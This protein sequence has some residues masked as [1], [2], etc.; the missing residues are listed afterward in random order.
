MRDM[1]IHLSPSEQL[2]YS[3]VRIE[4]D[5]P[6]GMSV[7]TGFYFRFNEKDGKHVP[8]I[9]TNRHV[10]QGATDARFYIH[11]SHGPDDKPTASSGFWIH[12]F[13]KAWI[14]HPDS[15]VD[16]CVIPIASSIEASKAEGKQ[17]FYKWFSPN[18]LASQIDLDSL[19]ALEEVVMVGYPTG[20]WDSVHN[21]PVF[22]R[23]VTATHPNINYCGEQ[24]FLIDAACFPGS[25]GSPVILFNM[26]PYTDRFGKTTVGTRIRLLGV[27]YAGPQ[28]NAKGA[29]TFATIP[30]L[31]Q[32]ETY[33]PCNLGIVIKA[34]R[35]LEFE[36][37]LEKL[38]NP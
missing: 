35:L 27:L 19:S 13:E 31:P 22:R 14:G 1:P 33:I 25:S 15:A 16:L 37:L 28:F 24:E 17:L 5:M 9:V 21:M 30:A 32:T 12:G 11:W 7:G 20:L 36:P 8:A 29:I 4:C 3:T 2:A 34:A 38:R 26:G 10:V 18:S 6:G 23:G